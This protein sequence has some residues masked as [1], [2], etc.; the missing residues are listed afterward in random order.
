MMS[1]DRAREFLARAKKADAKEE[2]PDSKSS[3]E[4]ELP[5]VVRDV[6]GAEYLARAKK[7]DSKSSDEKKYKMEMAESKDNTAETQD[8]S[9]SEG[10]EEAEDKDLKGINLTFNPSA[11][12]PSK[13]G[14]K[15]KNRRKRNHKKKN[16]K[17][18]NKKIK[19]KHS[20][21]TYKRI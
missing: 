21:K 19:K 15:T 10:E 3:D 7:P 14:G 20:R 17:K 9:D 5:R 11:E 12:D 13:K 6:R 18:T 16:H 1:A 4:K 8:L 2:K